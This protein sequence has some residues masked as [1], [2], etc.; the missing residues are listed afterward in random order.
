MLPTT[1][2]P[3]ERTTSPSL[4]ITRGVL[5]AIHP[6]T[7]RRKGTLLLKFYLDDA[8]DYERRVVAVSGYVAHEI[9][10]DDLA[11]EWDAALRAAGVSHFHA[12]DFFSC[13]GEFEGWVR[14]SKK[15]RR[16]E[17]KF[18]AITESMVT[19]GAAHGV[20]VSAFN[21]HVAKSKIILNHTQRGRITPRMWCAR[22]SLHWLSKKA[23]HRPDDEPIAVVLEGGKGMGE[24]A[25]YLRWLKECEAPWMAPFV[26]ITTAGKELVQLQ[27]AD[28]LAN[29]TQRELL[30]HLDGTG[31]K[32]HRS[33]RRLLKR[34][35]VQMDVQTDEQLATMVR[36]IEEEVRAGNHVLI[37]DLSGPPRKPEPDTRPLWFRKLPKPVRRFLYRLRNLLRGRGFTNG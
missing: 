7:S 8:I 34:G 32:P 17:R 20:V 25:E 33:M 37:A 14:G 19:M 28:L 3:N 2:L 18:S 15:H 13:L 6:P 1:R 24:A 35:L 4:D 31:S 11:V 36:R 21:K 29:H 12:T 27:A 10:W 23:P 16:F 9:M 30:R 5:R 22:E 26:S